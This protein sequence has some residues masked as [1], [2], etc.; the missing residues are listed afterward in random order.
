MRPHTDP[1]WQLPYWQTYLD[2]K[3][4]RNGR[5]ESYILAILVPDRQGT[6]HISRL[7]HLLVHLSIMTTTK[8]VER[9]T[10]CREETECL[11]DIWADE[12]RFPDVGQHHTSLNGDAYKT[13]SVEM[14]EGGWTLCQTAAIHKST[15]V[16]YQRDTVV[17]IYVQT[18]RAKRETPP[19]FWTSHID[20][21]VEASYV[22]LKGSLNQWNFSTAMFMA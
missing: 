12:L 21:C 22:L 13:L 3:I 6:N 20:P 5:K 18:H 10:W 9:L 15:F 19:C 7:F 17:F 16:P 1:G 4:R 8:W 14:K 2:R 11:T